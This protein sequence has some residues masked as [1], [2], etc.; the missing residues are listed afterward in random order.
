MLAPKLQTSG[1]TDSLWSSL[2]GGPGVTSP[3]I[4]SLPVPLAN[5]LTGALNVDGPQDGV[6]GATPV[7]T[8]TKQQRAADDAAGKI[9]D[10]ATGGY[11]D[12]AGQ[13]TDVPSWVPD[14]LKW[15]FSPEWLQGKLKQ[16]GI[17]IVLLILG[18]AFVYFGTKTLAGAE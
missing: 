1:S 15:L 12:P 7:D 5:A 2:T 8:R 14:V 16:G 6:S 4:S 13:I 10:P 18:I 17:I 3:S 9:Y 11:G